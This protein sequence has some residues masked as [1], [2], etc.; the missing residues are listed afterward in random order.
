MKI[1][2]DGFDAKRDEC[3]SYKKTWTDKAFLLAGIIFT[4]AILAP[5]YYPL[6]LSEKIQLFLAKLKKL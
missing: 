5:I 6:M 3:W 4:H 2:K 1:N